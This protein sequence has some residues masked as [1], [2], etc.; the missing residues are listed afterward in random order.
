MRRALLLAG[1]LSGT[2]VLA[3]IP[4]ANATPC[5]NAQ[6]GQVCTT[7][8]GRPGTCVPTRVSRPDYSEGVPPKT[9]QVEMLLCVA[10][11]SARVPAVA[12]YVASGF[13]LAL[14][15]GLVAFRLARRRKPSVTA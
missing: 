2:V 3:D 9:K 6:A 5:S 7:D 13:V 8:D 11:A 12:P 4:P 10:T 1:L 15:A 14:L